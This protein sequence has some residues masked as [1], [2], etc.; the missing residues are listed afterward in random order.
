MHI[1]CIAQRY[2]DVAQIA[3]SF[4][5]FDRSPLEALIELLWLKWTIPRQGLS[6]V[7][8]SESGIPFPGESIPRADHLADVASEHPIAN[9]LAQFDRNF[10]FQFDSEIGNAA[11]RVDGAVREDTVGGA[12]FDAA[13]QVPQ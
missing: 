5:A 11:G 8:L 4:G 9:L 13:V 7:V 6:R 1:A 2:R 12:G 10:V 3:P